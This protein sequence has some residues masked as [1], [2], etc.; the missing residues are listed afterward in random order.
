MAGGFFEI[1]F[2]PV[3][4]W[5]AVFMAVNVVTA[6]D[7]EK[8]LKTALKHYD[9]EDYSKATINFEAAW[10]AYSDD[11]ED[12]Y[13]AGTCHYRVNRIPAALKCLERLHELNPGY[14]DLSWWLARAYHQNHQFLE[15]IRTYKAAFKTLNPSEQKANQIRNEIMRCA[16]GLQ[17]IRKES[18]AII[19]PLGSQINS[20]L[21]EFAVCPSVQF[22]GK[23][24]FSARW[25]SPSMNGWGNQETSNIR[26][27]ADIYFT[28]QVQG[29]WQTPMR[30]PSEISSRMDEEVLDFSEN[31]SVM[32]FSRGLDEHQYKIY[33]DTFGNEWQHLNYQAFEHPLCSG[34]GD[35]AL[36]VFQDSILIFSSTRTGGYGA[37][38]LYISFF[39]NG[40]WTEGVNLGPDV[41]GP[42]NDH[43]PYLS[44]DGRTLYFSSDRLESMGG[45]DLFK[46]E[47]LPEANRWTKPQ[48]LGFPVN[49]AGN[50]THFKLTKDGLAAVITSDRKIS[51]LG[52][53]DIYMVYF[54]EALEEQETGSEGS[55][56][57]MQFEVNGNEVKKEEKEQE[58]TIPLA[59]TR[60]MYALDPIHYRDEQFLTESKNAA[61]VL[62]LAELLQR[63]TQAILEIVG[64]VFQDTKD[65]VQLY[66]SVKIAETLQQALLE[67]GIASRRMH[68]VGAGSSFPVARN[69]LH[70]ERNETG[71]RLNQRI[72]VIVRNENKELTSVSTPPLSIHAALKPDSLY[73]YQ[74]PRRPLQYALVL[75]SAASILNHALIDFSKARVWVEK[76]EATATYRYYFGQFSTFSEAAQARRQFLGQGLQIGEIQAKLNGK[77]LKREELIDHVVEFPDLLRYLDHMKKH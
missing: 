67:K 10:G 66:Y 28:Q 27:Q 18:K 49:S 38:D 54:K 31:G 21:D 9:R 46:T 8:E 17:L 68:C 23:Y 50:D 62:K 73:M 29:A 22:D 76:E 26:N 48:N 43:Y 64:H 5:M 63:D 47:F 1:R 2:H 34:I 42:W 35:H 45:Y 61:M 33:T 57:A 16:A 20:P 14:K 36:S 74:D 55:P 52:A 56:L 24:Y 44:K 51:S 41:N 7:I 3:C 70:G 77:W 53:R 69:F 11:K 4:V 30:M 12:L 72:E 37:N 71:Q 58:I 75:G 65:P 25:P 32:I 13:K 15:A 19:E 59:T 6:Q 39:R 60:K 40:R